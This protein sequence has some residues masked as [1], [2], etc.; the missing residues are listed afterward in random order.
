MPWIIARVSSISGASSTTAAQLRY[1][2]SAS[3][4]DIGIAG[5]PGGISQ[6]TKEMWTGGTRHRHLDGGGKQAIVGKVIRLPDLDQGHKF[7]HQ[8]VAE[9]FVGE[10][11]AAQ[12]AE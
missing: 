10:L 8:R 9:C 11:S 7:L 1:F 12:R 3:D 5:A 2:W 6:R 4:S